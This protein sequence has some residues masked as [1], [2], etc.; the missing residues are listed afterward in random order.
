MARNTWLRRTLLVASAAAVTGWAAYRAAER[1]VR[2]AQP[3]LALARGNRLL[4]RS[5]R[6]LVTVGRWEDLEFLIGG[7]LRLLARAG[8]DITIAG[9]GPVP[10]NPTWRELAVPH[11]LLPEAIPTENAYSPPVQKAL[12]RLW[13]DLEPDVVL[14]FDPVFPIRVLNHPA[15][16]IVGHATLDLALADR[17]PPADLFAFA[18]R[19]PN[20]LIDVGPVAGT[21]TAATVRTALE[22]ADGTLGQVAARVAARAAR[23]LGHLYGQ[24]AGVQYAE[25]LRAV[26]PSSVAATVQETPRQAAFDGAGI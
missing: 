6:V 9:P 24:A 20:V 19:R 25:G 3:Q 18:T 2:P 14:T 21:K 16:G 15:H 17:V 26:T 1:A 11:P 7:T 10:V 8:S 23:F 13:A 4:H 22:A 12:R 5:H